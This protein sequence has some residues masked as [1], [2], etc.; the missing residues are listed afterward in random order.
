MAKKDKDK[1]FVEFLGDNANDVT[2]SMTLITFNDKQILLDCGMTQ[3]NNFIKDF[4]VNSKPFKGFKAKNIDYVLLGDIHGDHSFLIP[5]LIKAGFRGEV[6]MTPKAKELLIP[7][8]LNSARIIQKDAILLKREPYLNES[9]VYEMIDR[10]VTYEH[11]QTVWLDESIGFT[12]LK[13]SHTIASAQIEIYIKRGYNT[14]TILYT[15]DMGN[16]ISENHYVDL[17]ERCKKSSLVISEC[18]YGA[19]LSKGKNTRSKDLEKMK[20]VIN[21]T[22]VADGGKVLIPVFAYSRSMEILTNLYNLYHDDKNFNIPVICDSPLLYEMMIAQGK[23]LEGENKKLYDKVVSWSK[24]RFVRQHT[25]SKALMSDKSPMIILSSSGMLD[26]GRSVNHLK[27]IITKGNCHILFCGYCG[28]G[29][30]GYK[31]MNGQKNVRIEGKSYRCNCNI[32]TLTSFSSH[33]S[34]ENLIGYLSS[35][36]CEKIALVHGNRES[37]IEFKRYLELALSK[38]NNTAKVLAVTKGTTITL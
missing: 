20:T 31:I 37:K 22:C 18:T 15:S 30:L 35:I 11:G 25:E 34:H 38:S 1:I 8:Q 27:T 26:K 14:E 13:N 28:E 17:L 32:T 5:K 9:H 16:P 33:I 24:V 23:V 4:Q 7:M 21:K 3:T 10:I 2:G 12:F 6:I 19:K 29:T 36:Q